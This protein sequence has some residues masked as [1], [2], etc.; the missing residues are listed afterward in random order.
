MSTS[1]QAML[2]AIS[3]DRALGS[4][5]LFNHRH[6]FPTPAF[7][8]EIM[9]LWRC[10]AELVLIE[11]FR[12]AA[13]STLS[14]EFLTME[15]AFGNFFYCLLIGETYAKACQRL[16]AIAYEAMTN[17]KL[18]QLFGREDPGAKKHREQGV[19]Q[20]GGDDRGDRVGAGDTRV[21]VPAAPAG[22]G[23][24]G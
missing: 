21:Q 23:V 4:A 13:K 6:T 24:W 14:E 1:Q 19:F 5:V 20:V 12:D 2:K 9:D 7:H 15:G 17:V 16:E 11:A 8:V 18:H 22:S 10:D 3:E